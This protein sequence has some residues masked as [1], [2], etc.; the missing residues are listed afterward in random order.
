MM[1]HF[2]NQY[3]P[4]GM[5]K[6]SPEELKKVAETLEKAYSDDVLNPIFLTM[7]EEEDRNPTF[8]H[9]DNWST[10]TIEEKGDIM[11]IVLQ[12]KIISVA[13]FRSHYFKEVSSLSKSVED[14]LNKDTRLDIN[15]VTEQRPELD[16]VL[17][18]IARTR[19]NKFAKRDYTQPSFPNPPPICRERDRERELW[20]RRRSHLVPVYSVRSLG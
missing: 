10:L 2:Y 6:I 1:C 8:K 12:I 14:Q 4:E 9:P 7:I 3:F 11:A 18:E 20:R 16:K 13:D 17:K 15:K 19:S 5:H